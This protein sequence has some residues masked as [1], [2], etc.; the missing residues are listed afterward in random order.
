MAGKNGAKNR[1]FATVT[2][3][4]ELVN[5]GFEVAF[6]ERP[7]VAA[8]STMSGFLLQ[9]YF[10]PKFIVLR[11]N[12]SF[13]YYCCVSSAMTRLVLFNFFKEFTFLKYTKNTHSKFRQQHSIYMKDL[14][15]L[16][17]CGIRTQDLLLCGR[18][19]LPL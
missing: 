9:K 3:M 15:A 8:N 19:R 12:K 10:L 1:N 16:H 4:N 6:V 2:V 7:N 13:F 11:H 17:P 18:T 14:K 5:G